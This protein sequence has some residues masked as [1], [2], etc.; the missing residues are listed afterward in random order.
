[1]KLK[2]KEI[3]F[4]LMLPLMEFVYSLITQNCWTAFLYQTETEGKR[5]GQLRDR[6]REGV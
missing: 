1:M 2:L 5:A 6:E 4:V 3:I